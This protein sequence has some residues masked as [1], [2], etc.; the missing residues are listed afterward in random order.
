M[1]ATLLPLPILMIATYFIA[2][3]IVPRY[4]VP[5]KWF[6][7]LLWCVVVAMV[8]FYFRIKWQ[9]VVNYLRSEQYYP[10]PVH[11]MLKNIIRDYS[12]IA[13]AVCIYIIGDYR[14]KQKLNEE[15]IKARAEAEIKLL[16]GQL[17]PHFLFNSLNNIYSLALSKS[18]LTADSILKLTEL[19]D[20]LVYRASLDT[21]PLAKEVQL[22][23]NY[24][25]L[26]QL[27]YGE[28]LHISS[29][30]VVQNDAINVT[31]LILLPF[32]ENC[33]KHGGVAQ[34]GVFHVD[35]YLHS[36]HQQLLFK[37]SNSKKKGKAPQ[38]GSGGL[39]LQNIQKR[40]NLLYPGRHQLLIS[41][42]EEQYQV[43]LSIRLY[44]QNVARP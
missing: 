39:G 7:F 1:R 30:I 41:N 25:G 37:M 15:L 17:H 6:W 32:A 22:L 8:V 33:F 26:E 4:L 29:D 35:I 21:V 16:K 42:T 38:N 24:L 31:P 13:L 27:R 43:E 3:F 5:Q 19:L 36:D 9:E 34:D 12:I 44:E 20:Y 40:L 18:D 23:E 14:R 11:K 2:W 10:V 28:K